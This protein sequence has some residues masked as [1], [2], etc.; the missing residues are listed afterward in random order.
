MRLDHHDRSPSYTQHLRKS[1]NWAWQVMQAVLDQDQVVASVLDLRHVFRV[2]D[3]RLEP[4]VKA[5]AQ[6]QRLLGKIRA[7]C[8]SLS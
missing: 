1:E 5:T 2:E 3:S 4:P 6:L 8:V 7:L